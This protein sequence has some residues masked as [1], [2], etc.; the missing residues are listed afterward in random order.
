M[1]TTWTGA[2]PPN[3][4]L[5]PLPLDHFMDSCHKIYTVLDLKQASEFFPF[6]WR[7]DREFRGGEKESFLVSL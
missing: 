5:P 3:T 7:V 4:I 1:K 6:A 2:N